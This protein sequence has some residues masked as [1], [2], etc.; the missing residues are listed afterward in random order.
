MPQRPLVLVYQDLA[1]PQ[2]TPVTPDLNSVIVGPAYVLKDYPDDAQEILLTQTYGQLEQPAGGTTPY[3][4]PATGTD[5]VTVTSWP[6]NAAGAL[7]DHNSARV[8][9]R[10][11]RVILG[12]TNPSVLPYLSPAA[13]IYSAVSDTNKVTLSG[14]VLVDFVTAGVQAGDRVI[15]TDNLGTHNFVGIV[16]SVGEPNPLTGVVTDA[17]SLRLTSSFPADFNVSTSTELRVERTLNT[18]EFVDTSGLIITFPEAGSDKLVV[19]GGLTLP[20]GTS[21]KVVSYAQIYLSYRALR[22][23]LASV[24]SVVSDDIKIDAQGRSY[25]SFNSVNSIIDARN[26]LATGLWLALLNAGQAPMYFFGVQVNDSSGHLAARAAMDT[27]RDL[28]MF[29]PLVMDLS[30]LNSYKLEWQSLADPLEADTNGIPQKFRMVMG[31]N[32]L[33]ATTEVCPSSITGV[34]EQVTGSETNLNRTLTITGSPSIDIAQVLP[35][36]TLL[37]GL[38]PGTGNWSGRRGS[39]TVGHVNSS[40]DVPVGSEAILEIIPGSTRWSDSSTES[41][42]GVEL[43][44]R[45]A[46]GQVKL[47][48]LATLSILTGVSGVKF[49][50]K[51]PTLIGGPYRIRYIDTGAS[52]ITVTL[53]GFDITVGIQVGVTTYS[54]IVSLINSD[55]T[56]GAILTASLVGTSAAQT[57]TVPYTSIL[58]FSTYREQST[59][60]NGLRVTLRNSPPTSPYTV[61]YTGSGTPGVTVTVVG[62]AIS[63]AYQTATSTIN[64]IIA[65]LLA[66]TDA[67]ALVYPSLVGTGTTVMVDYAIANI[68]QI[69]ATLCQVA[70]GLNDTLFLRL[71][72]PNAKFLV[73]G[74]LAGDV[75]EIPVDPN[76]Y[77]GTAF[78]GRTI[79]YLVAQVFNET[80]LQIQNLGDDSASAANE[81]PHYF[82]R[83]IAGRFVDNSLAGS[84][85]AAQNYRILRPMTTD[86]QVTALIS[87]AQGLRSRR[88]TFTWPDLMDVK[89]LKDGS[90]PRTDPAI[91]T[92]AA[93]QPG[94]AMSC[95]IAGALAGLPV[96]QGLTKLGISG[97]KK[98]YHS[99]RYFRERQLAQLSNGGIFVMQQPKETDL[100]SCIHQL[101]TD[102]SSL[103]TGEL[104]VAR[105]FDYLAIYFQSILEEYL[106]PYN[107]LPETLSEMQQ[108]VL[109]GAGRVMSSKVGR[110]GAPLTD[111]SI[112]LIRVSDTASD[113]VQMVCKINMPKPLNGVD[114]HLVAGG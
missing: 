76:N 36:D 34:A 54:Q 53:T 63:V 35:G 15:L 21:T 14:G 9:L 68:D 94:W 93:S 49:D 110:I 20:V 19:K 107:V 89:D 114:L 98:L 66:S 12:S 69:G 25:F 58:P 102:P 112:V 45:A 109:D 44:I 2:A 101:T 103:E 90:L 38:T 62:S 23:D 100:P 31:S 27:R 70:I 11:P 28:N 52:P 79:S 33:P 84:P 67:N 8:F 108:A 22:Q 13:T 64:D 43:Q 106:G 1:Q 111:F 6:G 48:K 56:I 26:P 65:A 55:T 95:I 29:V 39:H 60:G 18:Q 113:R 24:N 78:T 96:Q 85:V 4:P 59:G 87:E 41:A 86:D 80:R 32:Y 91:R 74:V 82:M 46:N 105:N 17:N 71:Y 3:V 57:V 51:T 42:G 83:D 81:L 37:I 92:D 75:I 10:F 47:S 73:N 99:S 50:M 7:V 40:K 104:S 72:D 77:T 88:A 16:S 97:I 61:D 30:I 5:A